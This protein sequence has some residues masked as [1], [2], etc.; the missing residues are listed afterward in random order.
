MP[1]STKAGDKS[2]CDERELMKSNKS[3]NLTYYALLLPNQLS[4]ASR[5]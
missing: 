4:L 3:K 1:S 2:K 5:L